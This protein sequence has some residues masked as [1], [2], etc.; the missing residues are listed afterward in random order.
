MRL[1]PESNAQ[2]QRLLH[3]AIAIEPAH[4]GAHALLAL[5]YW[6]EAHCWWTE[7]V[8]ATFERALTSQGLRP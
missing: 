7:E 4:A 1:T 8:G 6:W 5:A 2:A 3:D